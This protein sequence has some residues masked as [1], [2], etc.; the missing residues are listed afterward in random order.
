MHEIIGQQAAV[1]ASTIA[2]T[3]LADMQSLLTTASMAPASMRLPSVLAA[4]KICS[5]ATLGISWAVREPALRLWA[6]QE[7]HGLQAQVFSP[8]FLAEQPA[9]A[10]ATVI[11][12]IFDY[13]WTTRVSCAF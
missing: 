11:G 1:A 2:C 8:L 4:I 3:T 12:V 7:L 9:T 5:F 6:D 10:L 13:P